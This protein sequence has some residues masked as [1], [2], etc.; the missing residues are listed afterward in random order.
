MFSAIQRKRCLDYKRTER[1]FILNSFN[2]W[3][4]MEAQERKT[5]KDRLKDRYLLV[6]RNEDTFQEVGSY[7]LTLLNLYLLLSTIFL[8]LFVLV[9]VI[10]F[11]TPLRT[12]VPGYGII[13]DQTAFKV[14][15]KDYEELEAQV[16]A[17]QTYINALRR[18]L[19]D[20]PESISDVVQN[21][22]IEL[23]ELAPAE[24]IVEDSILRDKVENEQFLDGLRDILTE[25]D[26]KYAK[27]IK[28]LYFTPPVKGE[29]SA[30][31]MPENTHYGIDVM[32]PKNTPVL[33][34]LDGIVITSDWTL[35]TGNTLAVQHDNNIITFYKHNSANLKDVGDRVEAG[36]AIA[37][38]GN[39]GT[40]TTGP[41]LH[42]ELWV[43]GRAVDPAQYVI[44][45]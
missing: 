9:I 22:S 30:R 40:I 18:M 7:R 2:F 19:T 3:H 43:S 4:H 28:Q 6:I 35:E 14:M 17:Q 39:T 29:I 13:E 1:K 10:F 20:D 24:R 42:F 31:F 44:F 11:T 8:V 23:N 32:A 16:E 34:A 12:L 45:D 33:S 38:I 36:E 41:H 37:I 27:S 25:P 26:L 15:K 5:W 21:D